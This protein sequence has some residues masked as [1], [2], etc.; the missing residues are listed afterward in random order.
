MRLLTPSEQRQIET[1]KREL[2]DMPPDG[3]ELFISHAERET[4]LNLMA[5]VLESNEA[6]RLSWQ[7]SANP[8]SVRA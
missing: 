5:I 7:K 1:L 4:W 3:L 2:T 8:Q 6:M